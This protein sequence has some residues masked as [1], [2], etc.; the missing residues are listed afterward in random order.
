M[1]PEC[2]EML[3]NKQTNKTGDGIKKAELAATE[4]VAGHSDGVVRY[5]NVGGVHP[6]LTEPCMSMV[7]EDH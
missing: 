7:T 2:K 6:K 1:Q 3:R 4:T 5:V